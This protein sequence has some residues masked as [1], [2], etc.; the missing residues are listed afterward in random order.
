[1]IPQ[2]TLIRGSF[3]DMDLICADNFARAA[4]SCGVRHIIYLSGLV[5]DEPKLSRHLTSRLEVEQTF[6]ASGIRLTTLR[7][8]MIVGPGS[9]SFELM[10]RL[11]ARLPF[12]IAPRWTKSKSQAIALSDVINVLLYV[13][14]HPKQ[15]AG[16][17]DIGCPEVLTYREMM[18]QTAQALGKKARIFDIPFNVPALSLLGVSLLTG[19]PRQ[20]VVP[21]V[22]S[23]Q[24]TMVAK[25]GLRLQANAGIRPTPFKK[26]IRD[27][28]KHDSTPPAQGSPAEQSKKRAQTIFFVQ[29]LAIPPGATALW[30]A[31]ECARWLPKIL[32]PL[33]KVVVQ[34]C[35]IYRFCV[36]GT[37]ICLLELTFSAEQSSASRQLFYISGGLWTQPHQT[38]LGYV[39]FRAVFADRYVLVI[40]HDVVARRL[41]LSYKVSQAALYASVMYYFGRHLD[42]LTR[43]DVQR[44]VDAE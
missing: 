41:W 25:H 9:S 31:R 30:V 23:L 8:G 22:Q 37:D 42:H 16:T 14:D 11:V 2:A 27:A 7:A 35:L 3:E 13:L 26:A 28:I 38:E 18:A 20:L 4:K 24:H 43:A 21:L 34:D 12:I 17:W 29:R 39:E 19:T 32:S 5:P 33:I 15:C 44:R 36:P 6:K 1:M 40:V 10:S